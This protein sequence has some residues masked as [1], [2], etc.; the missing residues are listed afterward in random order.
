MAHL[1][2]PAVSSEGSAGNRAYYQGRT[3]FSGP[4]ALIRSMPHGSLNT[5]EATNGTRS[6]ILCHCF[7]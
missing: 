5:S 7:I 2:R 3:A 1:T 6:I 4:L